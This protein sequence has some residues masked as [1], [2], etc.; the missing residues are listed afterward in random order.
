MTAALRALLTRWRARRE[1]QAARRYANAWHMHTAD[2]L[3][4]VRDDE[5]RGTF[6]SARKDAR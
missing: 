6:V 2:P 3:A 1:A 4:W 5:W